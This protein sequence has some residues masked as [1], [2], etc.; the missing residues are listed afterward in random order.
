MCGIAGI[1]NSDQAIDL[2]IESMH[3]RGPDAINAWQNTQVALGH[4]RLSILDP[5]PRSNQPMHSHSD[6]SVIVYNGEVYNHRQ[7]ARKWQ[8]NLKTT[9]DTEVVLEGFEKY[10]VDILPQL[11]G[12]FS[13]AVFNKESG[14]I[15]V[16]R[17][18]V[19]IKPL[20]YF[21]LGNQLGFASELKGIIPVFPAPLVISKL[22]VDRYLTK[23]FIPAPLSIYEHIFKLMPGHYLLQS[24][25]GELTRR[26]YTNFDS[27]IDAYVEKN[28][29]KVKDKL[30]SLLM[31][32]VSAQLMSDV[33]YGSFLSGGIDSSIVSAVAAHFSPKINTF[34]IGIK[35]NP[36]NEL[37]YA[38]QVANH[39]GATHHELVIDERMALE[40]VYQIGQTY[41][42]P[43]AD[44]SA[45]PTLLLSEFA[46]R[47]IKMALSG[48]GGDELFMGYGMY[49]W[50]NRLSSGPIK[51]LRH[52]LAT[53]LKWHGKNPKAVDLLNFDDDADVTNHVFSQEMR[54]FSEREKRSI[55][56]HSLAEDRHS[57]DL[58]RILSPR[59]RQSFFDLKSY[60]PDDLLVK[61]DRASMRYGLEVR[62]PL[63]N[64]RLV[65]FALNIDEQLK[66]RHGQKKYIIKQ[67]LYDFVPK[68]IFDR[69]KWGFSIPLVKWLADDL[70]FLVNDYLNETVVEEFGLV[71][72]AEVKTLTERFKAGE[73][74]L[75][76]RVWL[77]VVLHQWLLEVHLKWKRPAVNQVCCTG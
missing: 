21:Y 18:S 22:A 8:L 68:A 77:L 14:E 61:V 1:T 62:V 26:A 20:Y 52:P 54:L 44:S 42:E 32:S 4:V 63:L 36:V 41:D 37:P 7:L 39:I 35:D 73:K 9:S 59:E 55:Y 27:Q 40:K 12:M 30:R 38:R 45:M 64:E 50:A 6:K 3:H 66:L 51:A 11:E 24:K 16:A 71:K 47:H 13:F 70:A 48:D 69:P 15:C 53:L 19:G 67:V 43:Y 29:R 28:E 74:H 60:L 33:P 2:A 65:N 10:G 34:S 58:K 49:D 23:G 25:N 56:R 72:F 76:N 5:G 17:D 75:Y 46:S 57:A 31:E